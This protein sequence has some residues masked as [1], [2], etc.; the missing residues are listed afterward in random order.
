MWEDIIYTL[1]KALI[2]AVTASLKALRCTLSEVGAWTHV[3]GKELF[4]ANKAFRDIKCDT[5]PPKQLNQI[6]IIWNQ[7]LKNVAWNVTN[8]SI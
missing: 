2:V 7:D 3:K 6:R 5:V 8:A 4:D 1:L